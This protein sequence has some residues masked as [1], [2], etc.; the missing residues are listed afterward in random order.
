MKDGDGLNDVLGYAHL[1]E[2]NQNSEHLS[3]FTWKLSNRLKLLKPQTIRA[4]TRTK[5]SDPS[6]DRI[7][8]T[9]PN[10]KIKGLS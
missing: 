3:N 4:A 6:Q 5:S 9:G 1:V 8:N 2:G 10:P 7:P